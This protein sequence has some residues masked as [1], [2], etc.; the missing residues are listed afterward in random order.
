MAQWLKVARSERPGT[1]WKVTGATALALLLCGATTLPASAQDHPLVRL[2]W[3]RGEGADACIDAD[4]LLADVTR[5]LGRNPFGEPAV[6]RLEGVV[7]YEAT[8]PRFVARL[9]E[10]DA[11]G[12]LV[13]ARVLLSEDASCRALDAALGLAVAL[14]IDPDAALGPATPAPAA[15]DTATNTPSTAV[16][17]TAPVEAPA[18]VVR[19]RAP[20]DPSPTPRPTP[21]PAATPVDVSASLLLSVGLVPGLAPGF[22]LR[23]DITLVGA[24]RFS[25]GMLATPDQRTSSSATADFGFSL[26]AAR[27]GVALTHSLGPV[28]LSLEAAGLVGSILAIVYAPTPAAP[29]GRLWGGLE[30]AGRASVRLVGPVF[31]ELSV[32][33]IVP[34]VRHGFRVAGR[35]VAFRQSPVVPVFGFGV[36]ARFP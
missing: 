32:A 12:A 5:R 23:T 9:Y 15:P 26:F 22:A 11:A 17:P 33:A 29:G 6:Q 34:L 10:R 19:G 25:M 31:A 35:E 16:E 24:L 14:A 8:P 1:I 18:P 21:T 27:A 3:V 13:G 36:G 7:V 20:V 30:L 2:S 28:L 4:V